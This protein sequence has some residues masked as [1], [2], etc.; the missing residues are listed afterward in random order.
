MRGRNLR[1]VTSAKVRPVRRGGLGRGGRRQSRQRGAETGQRLPR[2]QPPA[3]T[4]ACA[5]A[6]A[7]V[8]GGDATERRQCACP[9]PAGSAGGKL[10]VLLPP[11]LLLVSSGFPPP[12]PLSGPA[13][14][15]LGRSSSRSRSPPQLPRV[16]LCSPS[17]CVPR[18]HAFECPGD[19]RRSTGNRLVTD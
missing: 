18:T 10:D 14:P 6:T 8:G 2:A 13:S 1:A 16:L 19:A 11:L 12:L 7:E 17:P 3:Q 5:Q 15:P 4:R 9:E